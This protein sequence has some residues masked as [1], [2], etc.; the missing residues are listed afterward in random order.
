MKPRSA[1]PPARRKDDKPR[2]PKPQGFRPQPKFARVE[3]PVSATPRRAPA[4]GP[5]PDGIAPVIL[6]APDN[7]DYALLDSGDGRKLERYGKLVIVR[8][9]AQALW[10]P[11]L[12]PE[13]WAAADAVFSGGAEED[14]AGRW[15]F[16]SET[17][18]ETW[19][20]EFL[21]VPCLGRFTSYRH[22][23]VFAE[24][25]AHW[26]A[27]AGA[28]RA[29]NRP[30]RL[31]NLFGYTGVASL[32][33][34]KEGAQV[35]HVDASRKAIG[36]ARENQAIAGLDDRPIRWICDDAMKFVE[37]E[38][39]RAS[40]Y[41][42]ILLDPPAYGRGPAGEVWQLFEHLPAMLDACRAILSDRPVMLILTAYAIRASF[43]AMHEL[44]RDVF[45]GAGGSVTSGELVL[46]E[47][48]S[49]RQL[50]TSMYSRWTPQ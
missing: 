28:I 35:T 2:A 46:R 10:R 27:I 26:E 14:G 23:G 3:S 25:A 4:Q 30:L 43:F 39:R 13:R 45:A 42:I 5:L 34:A 22:V 29:S 32:I 38:A 37:R 12:S 44:V 7:G 18:P 49:G 15:R 8:P 1:K 31:L 24:Q 9:E 40:R 16:A 6:T 17:M 36:W 48:A 20:L 11:A 33:A 41:D 19:P 50:S 21:G 47:Q